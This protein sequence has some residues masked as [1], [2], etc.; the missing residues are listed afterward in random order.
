MLFLV[1]VATSLLTKK[2]LK[3]D[4]QNKFEFRIWFGLLALL[5]VLG[6]IDRI[7]NA[8]HSSHN[9]QIKF[10]VHQFDSNGKEVSS[11]WQTCPLTKE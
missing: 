9:P 7:D 1:M 6:I 5:I 11:Q 8:I 4:K 2:E 3:M 10:K